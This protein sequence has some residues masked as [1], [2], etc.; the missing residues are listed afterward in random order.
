MC[1][2]RPWDTPAFWVHEGENATLLQEALFTPG[3]G[4]SSTCEEQT[5]T[6]RNKDNQISKLRQTNKQRNQENKRIRKTTK[7][8]RHRS[9]WRSRPELSPRVSFREDVWPQGTAAGLPEVPRTEDL[10]ARNFGRPRHVGKMG[11]LLGPF[12]DPLLKVTNF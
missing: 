10:E 7:D 11:H 1:G 9:P 8:Q 4:K 2:V 3:K 5:A 6:G 12:S